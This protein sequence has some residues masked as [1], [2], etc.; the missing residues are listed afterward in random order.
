M[1]TATAMA[2]TGNIIATDFS[3]SILLSISQQSIFH[4]AAGVIFAKGKLH[5]SIPLCKPTVAAYITP[6]ESQAIA[7]DPLDMTWHWPTIPTA[8][9][10]P[11][12]TPLCVEMTESTPISASLSLLYPLPG[13]PFLQVKQGSSSLSSGLSSVSPERCSLTFLSRKVTT[14]NFHSLFSSHYCIFAKVLRTI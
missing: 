12:L 13:R 8:L 5:D 7:V 2:H 4:T 11:S 10:L 14:P 9:C 6:R 1:Y 3:V